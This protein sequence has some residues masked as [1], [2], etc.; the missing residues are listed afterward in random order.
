[1]TNPAVVLGLAVAFCFGTSDYLSKGLTLKVG[2]YRTTVYTLATSG[3]IVIPPLLLLGAPG[4]PNYSDLLVLSLIAV[5]TF[6]AFFFMYRGYSRGNLSVVSP[7]VN[8][9]PI[10]SV[11]FALFVLGIHLSLDVLLALAGVILGILFVSV[12]IS[13]LGSERGRG[14]TPGVPEALAASLLFA[15]ALTSLGD[16]YSKMGYLLPSVAARVGG[17]FVG[18]AAGLASKQDLRLFGGDA[19]RRVLVMG[20]LEASGL[21]LFSLAFFYSTNLV[22]L[23]I[24]TTLAG[25]GVVFTVGLALLLL[26][27]KVALNYAVGIVTLVVSVGALLY[28]TA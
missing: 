17:A 15:V 11:L 4:W 27:E 3:A 20:V 5:S 28:L 7:V 24:V 23:P 16:A 19:L 21:T 13:A 22:V 8:S 26:R 18:L 1:M 14:L 10:F 25:M 12:D 9:F 2:F 6:A